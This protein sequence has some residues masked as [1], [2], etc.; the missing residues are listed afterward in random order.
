MEVP[1]MTRPTVM[2]PKAAVREPA[3]DLAEAD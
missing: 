1:A 3:E 2:I